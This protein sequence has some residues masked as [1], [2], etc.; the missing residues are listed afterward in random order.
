M[1]STKIHAIEGGGTLQR[2]EDRGERLLSRAVRST[3]SSIAP[4]FGRLG[5]DLIDH[6]PIMIVNFAILIWPRFELLHRDGFAKGF[7][8]PDISV[9]SLKSSGSG[10]KFIEVKWA[11]VRVGNAPK[12]NGWDP[13]AGVS[14]LVAKHRP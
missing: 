3:L 8:L 9:P 7:L 13:E 11:Q 1:I 4:S 12:S 6:H 14:V 10:S 2:P 5:G